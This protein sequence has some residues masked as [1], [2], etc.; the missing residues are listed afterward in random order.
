MYSHRFQPDS[1]M[2]LRL[3]GADA[4]PSRLAL[5]VVLP[6]VLPSALK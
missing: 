6:H 5:V 3:P 2:P 4:K 1:I